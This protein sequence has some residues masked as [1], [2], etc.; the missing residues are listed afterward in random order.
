MAALTEP[1]T[2]NSG[3]GVRA[4]PPMML[5]TWPCAAFSSGQNSRREPHAAEELQREAVEPGV[6]G[7]LD[8][9]AGAGRARRC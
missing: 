5:I 2:R 1:P 6:V 7:Q 9:I 8:E 3:S 4:A